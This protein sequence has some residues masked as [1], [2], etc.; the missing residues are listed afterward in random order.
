M[1]GGGWAFWSIAISPIRPD[2]RSMNTLRKP[3]IGDHV[4]IDGFLGVFEIVRIERNGMMVDLK[5]LGM[6]GPDYIEKEIL[7]RELMY[8]D[9]PRPVSPAAVSATGQ[10]N[11]AWSALSA[12]ANRKST[13]NY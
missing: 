9:S 3:R 11:G 10:T 7:T 6:P 8:L 4:R 12:V 13:V 2:D 5:H 1:V